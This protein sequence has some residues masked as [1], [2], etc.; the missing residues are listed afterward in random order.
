MKLP[1]SRTYTPVPTW[2]LFLL[3]EEYNHKY[4]A[5]NV[6]ELWKHSLDDNYS[7]EVADGECEFCGDYCAHI[8]QDVTYVDIK[9][10]NRF[11]RLPRTAAV[12]GWIATARDDF[13]YSNL[14]HRLCFM[15]SVCFLVGAP[16]SPSFFPARLSMFI[17]HSWAQDYATFEPA[18][19]GTDTDVRR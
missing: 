9:L 19:A 15:C 16:C 3:L 14:I 2:Q 17:D 7:Y 13:D 11:V 4:A 10:Y 6:E 5:I 18:V 8:A 1:L 12:E